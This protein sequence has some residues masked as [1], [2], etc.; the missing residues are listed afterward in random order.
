MADPVDNT[1]AKTQGFVEQLTGDPLLQLALK[2]TIGITLLLI[3]LRIARWL[4]NTERRVLLRA[5]VDVILAEFLRNITYAAFLVLLLFTALELSG[6]PTATLVAV[7]GT[8]GIAIG[9]AL[10]DSLAHIAAG[11]VLIVLRPFRVG[12]KVNIANQEGTIEG[13]YI[14]QTRLHAADNR[15]IVLMN[16]AVL[17]A[18]IVNYSLSAKR[19]AG[20]VL[21]LRADGDLK[22]ALAIAREVAAKSACVDQDPP[23]EATITEISERGVTLSLGVWCNTGDVDTLRSDLLVRLHEAF[24]KH[25]IAL[26]QA[27]PAPAPGKMP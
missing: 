18:P 12:D 25:D 26:A 14:F 2:I 16:G 22:Q 7:L 20:I 4:A 23:P 17:A 9:L 13:V 24:A 3:G 27:T 15:N 1:V 5:H 6:F 19:R 10:K 11:V 21:M 8:A